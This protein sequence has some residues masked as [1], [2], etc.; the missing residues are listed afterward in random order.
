MRARAKKKQK[1]LASV[2]PV[3]TQPVAQAEPPTLTNSWAYFLFLPIVAVLAYYAKG[4]ILV[5]AAIVFLAIGA[6]WMGRH[7]PLT[8]IFIIGFLRG[9]FGG[10]R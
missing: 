7:C 5:V 9:L 2:P 10:R 3:Q 4:P 6:A 1:L 8:T